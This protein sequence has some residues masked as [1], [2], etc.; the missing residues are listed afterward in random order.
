VIVITRTDALDDALDRFRAYRYIDGVGFAFH[1]PMG[2][3]A[4]STLGHDDLVAGWAEEYKAQHDPIAAPPRFD[5]LD[6]ADPASWRPALGDP[7][8]ASDWAELF[9]AQLRER[10]WPVVVRRWV[11]RLLPG[12]AGAVGHGLIRVAHAVRAMPAE[13]PPSTL[14]LDE[15]ARGLAYWAATYTELPGRPN[16]GGTLTVDDAVAG[17]PRPDQPWSPFEAGTFARIGELRQF[18]AA[19]DTIGPPPESL[20]DALGDLTAAFCRVLLAHP[21]VFP[22]GPVHMITPIT[23][24]RILIPHLPDASKQTLYAGLWR[25]GA[26]IICGF[27]PPAADR[28]AIPDTGA[29]VAPARSEVM[30]R[31]VEHR[32][33]H[34]V[35]FAEACLREHARRPDPAYLLAAQQ[36]I[37]GIPR[38]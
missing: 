9:G 13:G 1:G 30:A 16:L 15:L 29:G 31:A 6:A 19:L 24:T 35:K 27:L 4:L 32:D 38:W 37:D 11:P 25:T 3:E 10:P 23:A 22:Q 26:A 34:A 33:T 28:R 8:R 7:R 21:G 12:H 14:R 36:V 18:P 5:T 17:L 20:D 2:A